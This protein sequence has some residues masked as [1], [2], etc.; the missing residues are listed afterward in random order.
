M[1]NT[2]YEKEYLREKYIKVGLLD[3]NG[4]KQAGIFDPYIYP[5]DGGYVPKC[6]KCK[7]VYDK[8]REDKKKGSLEQ[9]VEAEHYRA[10]CLW[11]D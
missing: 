10:G 6:G 9:T 7:L 1:E 2:Y 4:N 8:V 11:W 3:S 5:D